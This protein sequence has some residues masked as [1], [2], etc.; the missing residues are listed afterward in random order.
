MSDHSIWVLEYG[1]VDRFPASN[2]FAAQPNE[3]HRRMPYCFALVRSADR[4]ALVDTGFADGATYRRLTAKYGR[5][6]WAAPVDVL[7]RIGVATAQVDTVI[8]TH[9]HFDHAGCAGAF[10]NAHVYIQQREITQYEAA[11]RRPPRFEYLTRSCQ[12]D[13]PA[14]LAER[15]RDGL[16]T[17][18]DGEHEIAPGLTVRPAFDTHTAGSQV[19]AVSNAADGEWI[20]AGDNVYSYENLEGLHGDGILAPIAM[21]TGSAAGWLDFADT[22][23]SAVGG[24]TRRIIPFHE[25]RIWER[26]PSHAFD[27]GLHLAEISL[28]GGHGSLV[29][30]LT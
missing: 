8:L 12:P 20:F 10:P 15:E 1:F 14:L 4:C 30:A 13:L 22:M 21:T 6:G 24:E 2:L 3:G 7:D 9:N 25:N 17:R 16:G 29:E 23:L 11:L 26:F 27:D 28:A 5:T 18:V 19:V